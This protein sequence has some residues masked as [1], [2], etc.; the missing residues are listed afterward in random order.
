MTPTAT[1]ADKW[2]KLANTRQWIIDRQGKK[3]ENL[4]RELVEAREQKDR[5]PQ[6]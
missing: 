4:E 3:I 1:P 2:R 5:K 6:A